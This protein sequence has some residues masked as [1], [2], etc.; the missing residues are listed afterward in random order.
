MQQ[1]L[2]EKVARRIMG[3]VE[4]GLYLPGDRIPAVRKL[5]EQLKVSVSTVLQAYRLLEDQGAIEARPQS[6]YYLRNT[7]WQRPDQPGPS[8]PQSTPTPVDNAEISLR[9]LRAT[10]AP[11]IVQFGAAVPAPCFLPTRQ[12]NRALGMAMR[13]FGEQANRYDFPPGDLEL[14]RQIARRM[15]TAGCEI[16]PAQIITTSGCQEALTL[17]LRAVAEPGDT[18]AIESPTFYGLLHAIEALGL[19]ALEVPTH[20]RAGIS[21]QALSLALEQWP[22]KACV[23]VPSFS[24]PL[25]SNMDEDS[26]AELV[27]ML[28]ERGI[29]LIEDDVY[30]DLGFQQGR[31]RAAKA[32]D[33]TEG[34]LLCS[35]VS[36][37]LSP[38]LRV[39]WVAPGRYFK[40]VEYLKYVHNMATATLPQ[41]AVAGFLAKGGYDHYLRKVRREYARLVERMTRA[42]GQHFPAGTRV[43]QPAGGFVLWVQLP[44]RADSM[45]LYRR[46]FAENISVAP[47]PLFSPK[48]K[49]RDFIRLNC[50]LPW[51]ERLEQALRT[52]GRLASELEQ[53]VV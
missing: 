27:T 20:P 9:L 13:R 26:R 30:G 45:T 28:N 49:Y 23:L 33:R 35:S 16:A 36:K 48:G 10:S 14:R 1:H 17:S 41:S 7:V 32:F 50:A 42:I 37:T 43:T 40:R 8:N 19:H 25:G 11:H 38:G 47:G 34:V 46:A 15:A 18:I 4:Q 6:G 53:G 39:G 29:A 2:Y 3:Q 5:S 51:D 24:N 21:L 12:I 31:P 52:V 22:V 44:G